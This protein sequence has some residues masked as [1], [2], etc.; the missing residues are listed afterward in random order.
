MEKYSINSKEVIKRRKK[1]QRTNETIRNK[2]RDDRFKPNH[3]NI[4]IKYKCHQLK[5]RDCHIC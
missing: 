4:H 1:Q 3:I 2:S 5:A